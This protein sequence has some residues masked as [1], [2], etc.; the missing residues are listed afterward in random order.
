MRRLGRD[1]LLGICVAGAVA[2]S[3]S[4]GSDSGVDLDAA[5]QDSA[6]D[7]GTASID[8]GDASGDSSVT[9]DDAAIPCPGGQTPCLDEDGVTR[10]VDLQAEPCHCGRCGNPC[11]GPCNAG[12]CGRCEGSYLGWCGP[13]AGNCP[14]GAGVNECTSL[15]T[16][17]NCLYCAARC[18][19]GGATPLCDPTYSTDL[20]PCHVASCLDGRA[21]CDGMDSN[22]CEVDLLSSSGH[23]GACDNACPPTAPR[24]V[25]GVCAL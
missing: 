12:V 22:G 6:V 13:T 24:C 23:C 7:V 11:D 10:C 20:G 9:T 18:R 3:Q 15:L 5:P 1:W 8:S 21:N 14:S 2:C 19:L 17:D 4:Y 25:D 16:P